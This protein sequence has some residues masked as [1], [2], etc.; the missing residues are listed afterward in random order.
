MEG[1]IGEPLSNGD[2]KPPGKLACGSFGLSRGSLLNP[3]EPQTGPLWCSR[4]FRSPRVQGGV[5]ARATATREGPRAE[6]GETA[7]GGGGDQSI[8]GA[9]SCREEAEA[10]A[11]TARA[12]E[13]RQAARARGARA[14]PSALRSRERSNTTFSSL[15]P[16]GS[17]AREL[18]HQPESHGRC[19]PVSRCQCLLCPHTLP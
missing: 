19:A 2:G 13:T 15:L 16:T 6:G 3:F 12:A 1:S 8:Q 17:A 5:H 7:R 4:G 10:R 11:T 9:A 18:A 14:K